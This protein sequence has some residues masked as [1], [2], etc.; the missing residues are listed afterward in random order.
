MLTSVKALYAFSN[1]VLL[2]LGLNTSS[3]AED[4]GCEQNCKYAPPTTPPSEQDLSCLPRNDAP[5]PNVSLS[6]QER[7]RP[8][9]LHLLTWNNNLYPVR[10]S[11]ALSCLVQPCI[12]RGMLKA[13]PLYFQVARH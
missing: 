3:H 10:L 5:A 1:M 7:Q 6:S 12:A 2:H 8:Q 13:M 11:A 4:L 9:H